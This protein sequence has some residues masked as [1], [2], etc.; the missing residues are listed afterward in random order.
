MAIAALGIH[1]LLLATR[2]K[3]Q[4][5]YLL[6]NRRAIIRRKEVGSSYRNSYIDLKRLDHVEVE[7][8][9]AGSGTI[10]FGVPTYQNAGRATYRDR[11][12]AFENI[13]DV[14]AV[15]QLVRQAQQEQS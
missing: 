7:E 2:L 3:N 14:Q 6:T 8:G 10:L 13:P 1:L 5:T 4:T 15:Y 11:S 12:R 9:K